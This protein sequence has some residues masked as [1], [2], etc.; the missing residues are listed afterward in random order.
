MET[1]LTASAQ[2]AVAAADLAAPS[3]ATMA[4]SEPPAPPEPP[5]MEFAQIKEMVDQGA[6]LHAQG[7]LAGTIPFHQG[8]GLDLHGF[9]AWRA[10]HAD[11]TG[12][13]KAELDAVEARAVVDPDVETAEAKAAREEKE[14]AEETPQAKEVREA[15]ESETGRT[16]H[17]KVTEDGS[18]MEAQGAGVQADPT[19]VP[20]TPPGTAE[21][22]SATGEPI[23]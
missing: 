16:T 4:V 18:P 10:A 15:W 3:P 11:E 7:I 17:F 19:T 9:K 22:D 6:T 14:R 13:G 1:D 5:P 2:D 23:V 21:T 12:T 20:E 8:Q